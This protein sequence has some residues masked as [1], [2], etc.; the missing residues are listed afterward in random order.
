M[1]TTSVAAPVRTISGWMGVSIQTIDQSP[2]AGGIDRM[3]FQDLLSAYDA[4]LNLQVLS[5]VGTAGELTGLLNTTGIGTVTVN[6]GT[7]TAA[8]FQDAFA[9]GLSTVAKNRFMGADAIVVAPEI[10]YGLIGL[11]DTAGRPIV[12][13]NQSGPFNAVGVVDVPGAAQYAAGTL[14]GVPVIIDPGMPTVSSAKP[15]LVASFKDTI[16]MEGGVRTR[17]L[18]DVDSKTLTVNFQLFG[19]CAIA[20]RYPAGIAKVVGTLMN[21]KAGY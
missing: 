6:S 2:L 18:P 4:R 11:S 13:P 3:V 10:W 17:V 16:L 19:Y 5:G 21:P 12:V 20:A 7:P 15:A 9:K 8:E 1:T 14:L